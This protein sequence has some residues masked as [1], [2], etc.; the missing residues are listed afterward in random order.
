MC[1]Q[2][3][4]RF[5]SFWGS[6]C[7]SSW[8]RFFV[9]AARP[10]ELGIGQ[11]SRRGSHGTLCSDVQV[12]HTSHLETPPVF[13]PGVLLTTPCHRRGRGAGC[14]WAGSLDIDLRFRWA[15]QNRIPPCCFQTQ[16]KRNPNS[17]VTLGLPEKGCRIAGSFLGTL[18]AHLAQRFRG[19]WLFS[20]T[21]PAPQDFCPTCFGSRPPEE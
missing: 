1:A 8:L 21:L 9:P 19:R 10:A 12:V 11:D 2:F 13:S 20:V 5:S 3:W 4:A 16:E 14:R 7:P 18:L 15:R 17:A 6:F